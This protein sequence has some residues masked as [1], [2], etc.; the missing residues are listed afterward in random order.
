MSIVSEEVLYYENFNLKN[1]ITPVNY[2]KLDM[3]LKESNYDDD[4]RRKLI[5]GFENGFELG[6]SGEIKGVRR[7]APNLKLRVGSQTELWNKVM[8][9][10]KEK[11]YAGPFKEPPFDEFIQSPIG[12]VP[13]DG[14]KAT[15]LIF[16]LS[17]PRDGQSI[18]SATPKDLTTVKYPE[19]DRA[20]QLCLEALNQCDCTDKSRCKCPI[21]LAKSDMRSAFRQLRMKITQFKLLV[22]KAKSPIDNKVYYFV[23]KCLPFG[24]AISCAH[25]QSF[26]NAVAHILQFKTGKELMNYLDDF[27]FLALLRAFCDRQVQL[28][29]D[30]CKEINFPVS[31]EKTS[32]SDSIIVFLGLL[33]DTLNRVVCIPQQKLEKAMHLIMEILNSK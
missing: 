7:F 23:D 26:S 6:F 21:Y 25:F 8:K 3:L 20:I 27:L 9:E 14:G 32:W 22:I 24:A 2:K 31:L 33:I 29:L 4:K 13:K 17:Y 10:V 15:R 28:F 30:L 12:L 11:R 16:H 5:D 19:F 1:V 18:N